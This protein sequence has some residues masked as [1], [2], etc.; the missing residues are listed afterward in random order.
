MQRKGRKRDM[1]YKSFRPSHLLPSISLRLLASLSPPIWVIAYY[2]SIILWGEAVREV[3]DLDKLA[4]LIQFWCHYLF[5]REIFSVGLTVSVLHWLFSY[6]GLKCLSS[7]L[8]QYNLPLHSI[9]WT[10]FVGSNSIYVKFIL[11]ISISGVLTCQH[12]GNSGMRN[13]KDR[14]VIAVLF[15]QVSEVAYLLKFRRFC[16]PAVTCGLIC[17]GRVRVLL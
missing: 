14:S 17:H 3:D 13:A 10:G 15:Y 16:N 11:V 12:C 4:R 2:L 9:A 8:M 1:S 6:S 7:L 5:L